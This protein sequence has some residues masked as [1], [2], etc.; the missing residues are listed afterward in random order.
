[1][2]Y[3]ALMGSF[4]KNK[5]TDVALDAFLEGVKEKGHDIKKLYI[6]DLDINNCTGCDY[7]S[8]TGHCVFKD[9]M[10]I[11]YNEIDSCDRIIVAAPIYFNSI[12]AL[13]K[14]VVDRF[15]RYW[16]IKYGYGRE[17]IEIKDKVGMFISV[18]GAKF[19]LDRFYY[20]N[21]VMDMAF[22]AINADFV[23]VY[24]LAETDDNPVSKR[25]D[26]LEELKDLG[27]N[28]EMSEKFIIQ[29]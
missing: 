29:R 20:G 15:Q 28:F 1:M 18:G 16:G 6:R 25:E 9:D 7:C 21:F 2:K 24:N 12:N 10:N 3:L 23:G 11:L 22:K 26:V 27:R 19:T 4:R 17:K 8:D 14:T 13:T 5:N